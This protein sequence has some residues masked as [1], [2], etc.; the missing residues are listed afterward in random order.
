LTEPTRRLPCPAAWALLAAL[1]A[2]GCEAKET[3]VEDDFAFE[4]TCVRC[5]AG[6]TSAGVHPT[7]KLRCVDCH[8][9]DDQVDVPENAAERESVFRDP[10]LI[11]AAHVK[12]KRGLARFFFANGIDDDN[13]GEVDEGPIIENIAGVDTVVDMGEI[14]EPGLHG[15]GMGEFLDSE[16]N[17]DLNYTRWLNPGDLRVATVGCG[18]GSRA[19][20]DGSAG[21]GCHQDVVDR[22]RRSIMVNQSAVINGAYYGNESWRG[23]F[24]DARDDGG[25]GFDPR[26]GAF[27]YV[28][29]YDAI[30]DCIDTSPIDG[31]E[32]GRA[33][34]RFDS[35]CLEG[36]ASAR[37]P[38]AAAGAPGNEEL[39]AFEA[40]QGSI[41]RMAAAAAGQ[42]APHVGAANP[43]FVGWGGKPLLDPDAALP[44]LEAMPDEE[45]APGIPDPVDNVLRGF[46]AYYP[47]NYPGSAFN[48]NFTFGTSIL[49]EIAEFKTANPFGRG[50]A[51]GCSSCHMRYGQDGAREGQLIARVE[52][53]ERIEELVR[54]PTTRH[55]E[56]DPA[57][58][59]LGVVDGQER[60]LGVAVKAADREL[61]GREQQRYYS[62]DHRLTTRI[63]SDQCG[64]C[65]GFVTRVNM[66]YQG[67]A[68]DEQRDALAR[69]APIEFETLNGTDVR[70]HDSWVRE[71]N[72]GGGDVEVVIPDGVEIADRAAE[73]DRELAESGL[74]PGGGGCAPNVFT[75]DCNNNGE[76]DGDLLLERRDES[77]AVIASQVIDEDLNRNGVLDLIDHTPREKS[78]DG[79][80]LRY[81]YG[82]SNGSTRL[83]DVHFERGM[84][85]ID[86]HMLQDTHGDGNIYSTNWDTIEIECE[87]CHGAAEPPTLFTSGANGGN[88]LRSAFDQDKRPFFDSVD[89]RIIQR[90]RV[91][92]GLFWEVPQVA[93]TLDPDSER[94]NELAA[95]AH[96]PAHLPA[97]AAAGQ[98]N[99]G[100]T[101]DGEPGH[102]ALETGGLECYSCHTSWVLN[103]M[104]CHM[105][106]NLGDKIRKK[107]AVDGSIE[108]V[109]GDNEVW[110]N[111]AN[112]AGQTNFQL[113]ELM[114]SPFVLGTNAAADGGRLAPFRSSMELHVS[115]SDT[116]GHTIFDNVTFTTFQTVDGNSGRPRVAT[117]GSA[118]NQTMPHTVRRRETKG[119]EACHALVDSDGRVRNDHILAETLGVGAGRYPYVGDWA[120]AA[121]P[122]GIE[123]FEHKQEAQLAGTTPGASTRFPGVIVNPNDRVAANVEPIF[124][125]GLAGFA[126]TDVA[127]V[128]N[129]ARAPAAGAEPPPPTLRDLAVITAS[130]GASAGIL[131]V[132][133]V[134][135]RGHPTATRPGSADAARVFTL[136]L[137]GQAR[138]LARLPP[139]VSDPFL[140]IA[141]G[142]AGL[143]VVEL[144]GAP[145]AAADA[146]EIVTTVALPGGRDASEVVLAGDVAYVGTDQGTIEVFDLSD[147]RAPDHAASVQG[148]GPVN[149]LAIGGF[150]LYAATGDGLAAWS[151]LEPLDPVVTTGA[152][153]ALVLGGFAAQELFFSGG[154]VYVAAGAGGV[155]D[156]D[157][158][159]PAEPVDLGDLVASI[160]PGETV[161]AADVVV[162]QLA[163]Q[164]WVLVGETT[165]GLVGL[166]LDRRLSTRERCLPDPLDGACGLDMDW[167]DPTVMGRDPSFDPLTGDFDA[168]DPSGA[169]FFRQA[170][171]ILLG[172]R[173][174][175]RPSTWEQIGTQT[176]RR[177]R[178]SFMPGTGV[179]SL[180]VMQRMVGLEVCENQDFIDLNGSG[181]GPLGPA[182]DQ[183][184]NTGEC[185]PWGIEA[186]SVPSARAIRRARPKVGAVRRASPEVEAGEAVC[187]LGD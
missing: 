159:T 123:L 153:D 137:P 186:S 82:G 173:R 129:F 126:G 181:L 119:C 62:A 163:G 124:D 38:K 1:A 13:D 136:P 144:T 115:I 83:M 95:V 51:S 64:L 32:D 168:D 6:L 158:T 174:L 157:V 155:L 68:E 46:R 39:P 57:T 22:V 101:F 130:D 9:G 60:L 27:G 77:G 160:A 147:P 85:C 12:P 16:L 69:R 37:D 65:H 23:A 67:M 72:L 10:G 171:G 100:S 145:A 5:H 17:R 48:F 138:A 59:D 117:S 175:A 92:P 169:P 176:G 135:G 187:E 14:A 2:A 15:I 50:H 43:R 49:P 116:D 177:V 161:D 36:K 133:D 35:D 178:D 3:V 107:V 146:A 11:E 99:T 183:F 78:V 34:P 89:G 156:I 91:T 90:S 185:Q 131:V 180:E 106:V 88:D 61:T 26:A 21:G 139:D 52:E 125:G 8:G 96:D 172:A 70:I 4:G 74:I 47:M 18:S 109:A 121:G 154:H 93:D 104:G 42:S 87:D 132:S 7:F 103:C 118:M 40:T 28:L 24:Q 25:G 141:D 134:S 152:D 54:D 112:Q 128:R 86:C 184:F 97:L 113:L 114:R 140:Y 31:D 151:I 66:A 73:R 105:N 84:H 127:L 170:P 148:S 53:G 149:G 143:T 55:R 150:T 162:S 164:T 58:Q 75:E 71:V 142:S 29:D 182:D 98:H 20:L 76:L 79:R 80:Q 122:G 167:R 30:D 56:F 45:V 108:L 33:Q 81:V 111:N 166:K 110:F 41:G 165:G 179:L 120:I 44:D 94:F 19:A 63:T 102:S